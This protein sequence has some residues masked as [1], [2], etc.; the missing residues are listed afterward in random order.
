LYPPSIPKPKVS[1]AALQASITAALV[2]VARD[3]WPRMSDDTMPRHALHATISAVHGLSPCPASAAWAGSGP[4]QNGAE[5]VIDVQLRWK[6]QFQFAGYYAAIAEGYYREE[7]LDVRLHEGGP[8]VTPVQEVLSGRAQYGEA[9]S[10]LLYE[11]LRGKPLVAL[12]VIFQHSPSVLLARTDQ[13]VRTVHD[14]ISK[15]VM[16]MDAQTDADFMAM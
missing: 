4:Q 9:N 11:R 10:E 5:Q 12:A 6:H 3:C 15:P 16:L 14:L 2:I 1:G 8:N 13:G 7:G